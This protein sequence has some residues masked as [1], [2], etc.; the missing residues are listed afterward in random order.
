MCVCVFGCS[1]RAAFHTQ[2]SQACSRW[3]ATQQLCLNTWKDQDRKSLSFPGSYSPVFICCS[4]SGFNNKITTADDIRDAPSRWR[5]DTAPEVMWERQRAPSLNSKTELVWGFSE[6]SPWT[7]DNGH[8]A[9][10]LQTHS[11]ARWWRDDDEGLL[12][13]KQWMAIFTWTPW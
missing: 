4:L 1:S 10:T 6:E 7:K 12:D 11:E 13:T 3:D 2:M 8:N 5:R 9:Q